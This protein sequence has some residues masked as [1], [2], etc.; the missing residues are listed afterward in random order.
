MSISVSKPSF[1]GVYVSPTGLETLKNSGRWGQEKLEMLQQVAQ[2][3]EESVNDFIL[4]DE[5][6]FNIRNSE[7]GTFRP[8]NPP[9][10]NAINRNFTC[11]ITDSKGNRK[12][13]Q[14]TMKDSASAKALEKSFWGGTSVPGGVVALYNAMN[15]TAAYEKEQQKLM[16]QQNQQ[17]YDNILSLTQPYIEE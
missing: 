11:E 15:A 1:G 3:K 6:D 16:D 17:L 12:P 14:M 2:N 13:F 7:Y 10:A 9:N 5:G 4:D 8:S